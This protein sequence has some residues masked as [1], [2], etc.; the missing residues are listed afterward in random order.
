MRSNLTLFFLIL[1][2]FH[3]GQINPKTKWGDVSTAEIDF[4]QVS[5]EKDAS[6][7]ILYESGKASISGAFQIHVYK[8]IK[9]LDERGMEYANQ[10][11]SYY[12][13]KGMEN[14]TGLKAQTINIENSQPV[15]SQVDK[16]SIFNVKKNEYYNTLRFTFPN[17]KV[18]SILEF[19]YTLTDNNLGFLDAWRFQH[20]IPTLYS[21]F[22]IK[23]EMQL[24]YTSIMIGEKIVQFAQ[25]KKEISDWS[26]TQIPS[27]NSLKFL[28]N[29][30][31]LAERI[32]FQLRGYMK[33][34]G[35]DNSSSSYQDV[36]TNWKELSKEL[37]NDYAGYKNLSFTKDI[38]A[39]IPDGKTE[40]ESLQNV[41]NYFKQ[42]YSWNNFYGISPRQSNRDVEK[43]RTGNSTELNLMLNSL[44]INKG[45]KTDLIL[46][47][48]R[49][50]GKLITSYP[51]LGQFNYLINL[52]S[53]NDGSSYVIDA[54]NLDY[55]LGFAPLRD[56]N[57][58][59]LILDSK[60]ERFITIQP[61]VSEYHSLQNYVFKDGKFM[62]NRSDKRNGY[63]K[64]KLPNL[65]QG[66]E[67]YN[68]Q[69]HALDLFTTEK[70]RDFKESDEENFEFERIISETVAIGNSGFVGIENPLKTVVSYFTL[71]ESTRER[72]L[73]F[74]FPFFHKTDVVVDI[75]PGYKIEI[76]EGFN[77]HRKL[78]TNE[79]VYFQ[80]AEIKDGKLIFHI[81]FYVG[82]TVF[83]KN[84]SEIK[85]FFD[86][87]NLD[88]AKAI[89]MKK[90]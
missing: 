89:L 13:Y 68:P 77:V 85:S 60:S 9:I 17:V 40:K 4:K 49:E 48:S 80:Q 51:Y 52:I 58:F 78:N 83:D 72:A 61:R 6:A 29:P 64:E 73:E 75:P 46:I 27:F 18:G 35:F 36:L 16:K 21:K 45:F 53:L 81:E 32:A 5:F 41:Y 82:K 84:Y 38:A 74:N 88:V 24:D 55:D 20:E 34:D 23:N 19:E 79:L 3:Y 33:S 63:F 37:E 65:P 56:Y 44:L 43:N 59:G 87:A 30:E 31:D 14:I 76:P 15:I 66:V 50:N 28:Y 12:T 86:K 90:I 10:E 57:H 26:L 54:S 39:S 62:I 47:S 11:I 42:N 22:E 25:N 69:S 67:K 2:A 70:K 8:R 71:N 1:F 7:V